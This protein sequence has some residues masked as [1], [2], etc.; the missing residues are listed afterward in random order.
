M[1]KRQNHNF[2]GLETHIAESLPANAAA[3]HLALNG[4]TD[5]V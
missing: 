2:K 4:P 5:L 1:A 3:H